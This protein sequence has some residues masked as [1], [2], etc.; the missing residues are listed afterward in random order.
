MGIEPTRDLISPT[1]ALKTRGTT[2]HQSPPYI[3]P[4]LSATIVMNLLCPVNEYMPRLKLAL[5]GFVLALPGLKIGLNW[6][7]LGLNWL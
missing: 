3:F 4:I 6:V 5:F 7:C 1:L 2:R